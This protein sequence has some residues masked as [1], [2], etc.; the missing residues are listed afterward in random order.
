MGGLIAL[1]LLAA[2]HDVTVW[3]RTPA[4]AAPL[5]EAGATVAE[6]PAAASRDAEAVLVMVADPQALEEVAEGPDGIAAGASPPTTVIQ[7]STVGPDAVAR[8]AAALP[9]G[10]G[11]LDAPVLGSLPEAEA[12]TLRVFAGGPAA[13]VGRWAPLLSDLGTV[14]HVGPVGAGSAAKLVANSTLFGVLGV[15]GE[16][17]ALADALGLP[18]EAAY[19]ILAATPL[20]A[21]A[22]R[23]RPAVESGE[24]P[25]RFTLSLALKDADLIRDAAPAAVDLR[26]T[27]AA[28]S[29]LAD[30]AES[31]L[32]DEDY[33]AVLAWIL[34][35]R[36]RY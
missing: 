6:S 36:P 9:E 2:G 35:S 15:L 23:R 34:G 22:E 11:L 10:V 7:M 17:L 27:D 30:A 33:S 20:A 5:A 16:A 3:N 8:F 1:R 29:W 18:R 13:L 14:L 26:V 24:F 19:D 4:K 31:G 28:R 21:Q 32:G 25:T 12:G